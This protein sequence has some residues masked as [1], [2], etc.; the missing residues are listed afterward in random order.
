MV[1]RPRL[2]GAASFTVVMSVEPD[3]Q[4]MTGNGWEC[5]PEREHP[6]DATVLRELDHRLAAG[7]DRAIRADDCVAKPA[8]VAERVDAAC[9]DE[10]ATGPVK[11]KPGDPRTLQGRWPA[12]PGM[13][14]LPWRLLWIRD[15]DFRVHLLSPRGHECAQNGWMRRH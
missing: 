7:L 4:A 3:A 2:L 15:V 5:L 13:R 10:A 1:Y 14:K 8:H 11:V 9:Q 12:A 6:G